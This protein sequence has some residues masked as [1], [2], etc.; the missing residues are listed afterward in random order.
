[1]L[2]VRTGRI[3]WNRAD[4]VFDE[5]FYEVLR[6]HQK[7]P[8]SPLVHELFDS[9]PPVTKSEESQERSQVYDPEGFAGDLG[10]EHGTGSSFS[11]TAVTA[12][13]EEGL[14]PGLED[15]YIDSDFE[16]EETVNCLEDLRHMWLSAS[17]SAALAIP[18]LPYSPASVDETLAGPDSLLWRAAIKKEL[19]NMERLGVMEYAQQQKGHGM[20][21]KMILKTADNNDFSVKYKA[22][23]VICGY[24]QVY[25]RDY[26]QTYSP[27]VAVMVILMTL[28]VAAFLALYAA[29]FDVTS[30]FLNAHNDYTNFGYLPKG[31]FG[32]FVRMRII[33]AMYGEKQAPKL[34]SDMLHKIL[35]ELGFER[36][37]VS[38]MMVSLHCCVYTLMMVC[39]W[40]LIWS[41]TT[42]SSLQCRDTC[43][44]SRSPLLCRSMWEWRWIMI[45][46]DVRCDAHRRCSPRSWSQRVTP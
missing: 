16:C 19:E 37:P 34:W 29:T 42:S 44:R 31:L 32:W 15:G 7:N 4:V 11:D 41:S 20:K 13:Y 21:M 6:E 30:A 45:A 2:N 17:A 27:T 12:S 38:A 18:P 5:S 3:V 35:L 39:S 40:S 33:K 1:V 10:T 46:K 26:D 8:D 25:G 28:H 24:S 22:R 9:L 43:L 23:L 14:F 36:C